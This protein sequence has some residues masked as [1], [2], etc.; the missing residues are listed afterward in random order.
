MKWKSNIYVVSCRII[1]FVLINLPSVWANY[2]NLKD[3]NYPPPYSTHF[4]N[5]P[6]PKSKNPHSNPPRPPKSNP[7]PNPDP[8]LPPAL[9]LAL[10]LVLPLSLVLALAPSPGTE[11]MR[12]L[13]QLY[14]AIYTFQAS[15]PV[16]TFVGGIFGL[17]DLP[18]ET[19]YDL[20][21][22]L[23]KLLTFVRLY[24]TPCFQ[25]RVTI[26]SC[27]LEISSLIDIRMETV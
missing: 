19:R 17:L 6:R 25:R 12:V 8:G 24:C 2:I 22:I 26:G 4:P 1:L 14:Q 10:A 23:G 20:L 3:H 15:C 11:G 7:H 21:Q 16:G 13:L 27:F 9:A 5:A 18:P